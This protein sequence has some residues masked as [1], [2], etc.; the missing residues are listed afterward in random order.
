MQFSYKVTS[1]VWNERMEGS[2]KDISKGQKNIY[3]YNRLSGRFDCCKISLRSVLLSCWMLCWRFYKT[4][5]LEQ[6]NP[7][8]FKNKKIAN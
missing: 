8:N 4:I 6:K 7:A 2:R 5:R 1:P 3:I